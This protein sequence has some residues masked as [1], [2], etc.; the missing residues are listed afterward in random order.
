MVAYSMVGILVSIAQNVWSSLKALTPTLQRLVDS[1]VRAPTPTLPGARTAVGRKALPVP[2]ANQGRE[3]R[4]FSRC[5][6][7]EWQDHLQLPET[8]RKV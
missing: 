7:H 6:G 5:S 1:L 2:G 3:R 8:A 4:P